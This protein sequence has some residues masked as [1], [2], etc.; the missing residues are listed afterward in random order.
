VTMLQRSPSYYFAPPVTHEL[1]VTLRQLDIPEEWTHEILRRQYVSQFH[2]LAKT[3][4]EAPDELHAFLVEG[5]RPL[6]P[7]GFDMEKHFTPRY[8]PWQQRIAIVPDGDFF[9]ALREEKA[10]MVTDTIEEF[11]ETGIRVSSGEEL[12][13]DIVVTATGLNLLPMGGIT[14][15]V[16]GAD[17][18]LPE[19]TVYKSMM[20]SGVP[21]FAF[22]IGYINASW[23]L[24]VDLVCEHLCR[25]LAYMDDRD[26]DMVVPVRG[27]GEVGRLPLFDLTSGYVLRGIHR[28]PHA[29]TRGPWTA[30]H[31]YERDV[32][33]LRTGPVEGPE[34]R[35]RTR[36]APR[37]PASVA[38]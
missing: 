37:E 26:A 27:D 30:E 9:A 22:A 12:E 24:K 38:A 6:L 34:L 7:E 18:D 1:A 3:S 15:T 17:V 2:W 16:D 32:E 21:N 10:S 11:T 25:L 14:F 8:R 23:T 19:T 5:I 28:F 4:L 20:L 33:R 29:G 35:F 13:A 31:A 36:T